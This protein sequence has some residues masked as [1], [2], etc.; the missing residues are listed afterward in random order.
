LKERLEG[1]EDEEKDVSSCWMT[2]RRQEDT[3]C[4]RRKLRNKFKA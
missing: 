1:Q 3:G 2:L 4:G